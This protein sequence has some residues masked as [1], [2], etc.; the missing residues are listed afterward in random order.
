MSSLLLRSTYLCSKIRIGLLRRA[1][2]EP[3]NGSSLTSS[4]SGVENTAIRSFPYQSVLA[5][6]ASQSNQ[7]IQRQSWYFNG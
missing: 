6:I 2:I 7:L 3:L 5:E 4:E 1:C